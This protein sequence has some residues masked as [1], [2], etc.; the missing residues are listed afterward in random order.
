MGDVV[1]KVDHLKKYFPVKGKL[2]SSSKGMV[3]AVDDLSF[4]IV[5]GETFGLVGESGCGKSTLS[6]T[7]LNLVMAD[8]GQVIFNGEDITGLKG[9]SMERNR[10]KMRMIFQQPYGSLNPRD[11]VRDIIGAP[12]KLHHLVE[13]N[14]LDEEILRLMDLVGLNR[15]WLNRFPHEFS[16]GQRQRIGIARALAGRPELIICDEPVSALDVSIQSQILNLLK[17]LQKEFGLTYLFI[18][19]NLSVVK[20]M[21]DR[22][23][24]MYL[25]VIVEMAES[26]EIY[27]H[28]MH[29][30]TKALLSAIPDVSAKHKKERIILT[31]DI[32]SPVNPPIGCRFC[33]RC[34]FADMRCETERPELKEIEK[35]HYCACFLFQRGGVK[36]G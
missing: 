21:A 33:T 25:G 14:K 11:R 19:H 3:H 35:G 29:P 28:A 30:Y 15:E 9:K 10:Q 24:V 20:F 34:T 4:E 6:R 5:K 17:D 32:K 18:S 27:E 36:N 23:A 8:G 16:G 26:E 22:I 31:G 2:F 7:V 13:R 12:L 1:L